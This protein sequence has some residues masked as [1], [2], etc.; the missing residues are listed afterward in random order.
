[1]IRQVLKITGVNIQTK[2]PGSV[3]SENVCAWISAAMTATVFLLI[4]CKVLVLFNQG[5]YVY[6]LYKTIGGRDA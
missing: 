2:W 3:I 5:L 4:P 1:M 6:G